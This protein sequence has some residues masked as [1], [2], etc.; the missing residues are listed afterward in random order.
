MNGNET[1]EEYNNKNQGVPSDCGC[2]QGMDGE[3]SESP[4]GQSDT[5]EGCCPN[6]GENS[7]FNSILPDRSTRFQTL[8]TTTSND[9]SFEILFTTPGYIYEG[10]PTTGNGECVFA[11]AHRELGNGIERRN[12]DRFLFI[13]YLL[14]NNNFIVANRHDG[15]VLQSWIQNGQG[16][17][18]S[19]EYG[20][21]IH[22]EC[23]LQLLPSDTFALRVGNTY[24]NVCW[25]AVNR[26]TKIVS[27]TARNATLRHRNVKP[28]EDINNIINFPEPTPLEPLAELQSLQDSGPNPLDAKRALIG[29][30]SIPCLF[31]N[32]PIMTLENRIKQSPY[33]I[34]QY[35]Q[36][37]HRL[38]SHQFAAGEARILTEI[39]GALPIA[40][41]DMQKKIDISIGADW[42]LRFFEKSTPF[43]QQ[44]ISSLGTQRS[45][46]D[47]NLGSTTVETRY[48][49]NS[50]FPTRYAMFVR[51][52]EYV[53]TRLDG[54]VVSSPWV[55]LD[56]RSSYLKSFPNNA[57]LVME[58]QKIV[59]VDN[60]YDLSVYK[61]PRTIKNNGIICKR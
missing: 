48:I 45:F 35:R 8:A 60:S 57:T 41:E 29:S 21:N 40:L 46:T 18:V 59:N 56:G 9:R 15:F 4:K 39:T 22:Q 31:V 38:W 7:L 52:Y 32:D 25:G 54:T 6:Y 26:W 50:F 36:Y 55:A 27:T 10:A 5:Y 43:R 19:R 42:G 53:L 11:V 17:L 58:H 49:N 61:T 51:A 3:Y 28:I 16:L 24:P 13:F 30:A 34:L 47:I 37:W 1:K 12:D 2:I 20:P 14:D 23:N 44:I 33:Y